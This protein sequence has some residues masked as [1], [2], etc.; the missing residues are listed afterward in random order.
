MFCPYDGC[1]FPVTLADVCH[2][3]VALVVRLHALKGLALS[4]A[5][6]SDEIA[7]AGSLRLLRHVLAAAPVLFPQHIVTVAKSGRFLTPCA[8]GL[9]L[10]LGCCDTADLKALWFVQLGTVQTFSQ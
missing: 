4:R 2:D 7:L 8:Q 3:Y 5:G 6:P 10:P 9:V 1:P